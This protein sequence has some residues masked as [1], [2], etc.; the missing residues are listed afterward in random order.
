MK[1]SVQLKMTSLLVSNTMLQGASI[2]VYI[3]VYVHECN[4]SVTFKMLLDSVGALHCA[5]DLSATNDL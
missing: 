1:I 5:C 4:V 3:K 2:I